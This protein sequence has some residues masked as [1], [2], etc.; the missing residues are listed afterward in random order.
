MKIV[1]DYDDKVL[2]HKLKLSVFHAP[3]K[4]QHRAMFAQY[5]EALY[6]AAMD[7][8]IHDQITAPVDLNVLFVDPTSP[9]LDH[10]LEALFIALDGKVKLKTNFPA[11]LESDGQ[12]QWVSFGKFYPCEKT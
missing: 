5:R 4:R 12:V 7:E 10:L 9:D 3:H 8:G 11:L 6:R 2:P 1:L